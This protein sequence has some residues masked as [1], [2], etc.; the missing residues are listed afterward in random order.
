MASFHQLIEFSRKLFLHRQTIH[1]HN[2]PPPLSPPKHTSKVSEQI[3]LMSTK[4]RLIWRWLILHMPVRIKVLR[5]KWILNVRDPW[6]RN[7]LLQ[8]LFCADNTK[9]GMVTNVHVSNP[10]RLDWRRMMRR[11]IKSWATSLTTPP[12]GKK[13]FT[14]TIR[15]KRLTWSVPYE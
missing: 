13:Y 15:L 9:P 6:S 12:G 14:R 2:A 11:W 4:L 1:D 3:L 10:K 8:E 5:I 7:L